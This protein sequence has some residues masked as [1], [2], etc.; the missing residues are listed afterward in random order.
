MEA[1]LTKT[2]NDVIETLAMGD[3]EAMIVPLVCL[4]APME[5]PSTVVLVHVIV[6]PPATTPGNTVKPPR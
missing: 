3:G 4:P 6:P 5:V 1:T 2:A